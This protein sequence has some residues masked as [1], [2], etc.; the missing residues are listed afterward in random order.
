MKGIRFLEHEHATSLLTNSSSHSR[1]LHPC[2]NT[3]YVESNQIWIHL[4]SNPWKFEKRK[5]KSEQW[6]SRKRG[7]FCLNYLTFKVTDVELD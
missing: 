5:G 3:S 7:F 1:T 2:F 4:P 6:D